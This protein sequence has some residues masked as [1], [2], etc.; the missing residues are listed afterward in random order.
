MLIKYHEKT[1]KNL[2]NNALYKLIWLIR[3]KTLLA[4]SKIQY[5]SSDAMYNKRLFPLIPYVGAVTTFE[6]EL[7]VSID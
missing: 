4:S 5:K 6:T 7:K 3:Q 1:N 2:G